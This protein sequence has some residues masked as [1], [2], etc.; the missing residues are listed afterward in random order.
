MMWDRMMVESFCIDLSLRCSPTWWS[1]FTLWNS[2]LGLPSENRVHR[3]VDTYWTCS[4]VTKHGRSPGFTVALVAKPYWKLVDCQ[5]G[6][7]SLIASTVQV[8]CINRNGTC[9][10]G[11]DYRRKKLIK[12]EEKTPIID[13]SG[14]YQ[15]NKRQK[16]LVCWTS[17]LMKNQREHTDKYRCCT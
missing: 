12:K 7:S 15:Q 6:T 14:N 11:I 8:Q 3:K 5:S 16:N 9:V 4:Y 17:C 2:F 1:I 13:K 10:N